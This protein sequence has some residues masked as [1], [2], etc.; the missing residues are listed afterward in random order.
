LI[1][2]VK[3]ILPNMAAIE[4]GRI[5]HRDVVNNNALL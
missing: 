5:D 2:P 4:S 1:P 3:Q